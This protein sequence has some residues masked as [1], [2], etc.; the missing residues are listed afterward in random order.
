MPSG[1]PSGTGSTLAEAYDRYIG[2]YSHQLARDLVRHS[3]VRPPQRALDVGCGPGALTTALV[4]TLG[5]RHVFAVDPSPDYVQACRAHT[6]GVDVRLGVA[7]DLPFADGEMDVV[8]AQLV[9]NLL[10]DPEGGV[11]EM[12]RVAR[13]HGVVAAT[14]WAP[15]G[16]PLLERFW[17]AALAV[18][19]E[20]VAAIGET[21]RVGFGEEELA[22]LWRTGGL[23]DV[24]V[25]PL[26]ATASY[27]HIAD[28]C[29][30]IE[31]GVGRSGQLWRSL[32]QESQAE[33][34]VR[35]YQG[36]GSPPGRF[37]LTAQAWCVR[38]TVTPDP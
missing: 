17:E 31:A 15:G 11:A 36:L 27:E 5:P 32:D 23:A 30:P 8:L 16:M 28:L 12:A 9:V 29:E 10:D 25:R 19:P 38:G 7:E 14:V 21:G 18:A 34:R 1:E 37:S 24:S 13:P 3:G 26:H 6:P 4:E 20:A 22:H 35:L 2:R 33:L